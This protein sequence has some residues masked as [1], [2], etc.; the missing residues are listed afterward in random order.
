MREPKG[1][2]LSDSSQ[3]E[4][5]PDDK[6]EVPLSPP[7]QNELGFERLH[8]ANKVEVPQEYPV[9]NDVNEFR[10]RRLY[11]EEFEALFQEALDLDDSSN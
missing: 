2:N 5:D 1:L 8:L 4:Q 11:P 10:C 3:S 7:P 9:R 6:V